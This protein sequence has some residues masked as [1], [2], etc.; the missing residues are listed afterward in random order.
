MPAV[1]D[2]SFDRPE[3]LQYL[4]VTWGSSGDSHNQSQLVLLSAWFIPADYL[5]HM[6][7]IQQQLLARLHLSLDSWLEFW[8]TTASTTIINHRAISL[9]HLPINS[10]KQVQFMKRCLQRR[11]LNWEKM[12][13]NRPVQ[14]IELRV[15]QAY[16]PGLCNTDGLL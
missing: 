5:Q 3:S 15:N 9:C 2:G 12:W 6:W 13:P 4:T 1:F 7:R 11:S 14:S 8:C 16:W 10:S